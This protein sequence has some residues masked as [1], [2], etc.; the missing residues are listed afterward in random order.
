M[1]WQAGYSRNSENTNTNEDAEAGLG[2]ESL[3]P[4]SF[5]VQGAGKSAQN[6]HFHMEEA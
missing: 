1:R 3:A 6:R 2:P 4:S 5:N